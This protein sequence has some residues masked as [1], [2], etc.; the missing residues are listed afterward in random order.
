M[1]ST[2]K[3]RSINA[4]EPVQGVTANTIEGYLLIALAMSTQLQVTLQS[5]SE[6]IY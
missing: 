6:E 4:L 1:K 3:S 2:H 5:T